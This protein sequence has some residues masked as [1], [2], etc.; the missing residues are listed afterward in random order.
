MLTMTK[1]M[2]EILDI[3]PTKDFVELRFEDDKLIVTKAK[4]EKT[5]SAQ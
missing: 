1:T 5:N 3:D 4:L 2:L